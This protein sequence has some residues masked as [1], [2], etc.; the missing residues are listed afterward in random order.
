MK[1]IAA[2]VQ[3]TAQRTANIEAS[4]KGIAQRT[5]NI[6]ADAEKVVGT[7]EVIAAD[8]GKISGVADKL[9]GMIRPWACASTE[10]L[11][12]VH[13]PHNW[14]PKNYSINK[15]ELGSIW[16]PMQNELKEIVG[17]IKKHLGAIEK[18]LGAFKKHLKG[19]KMK[20]WVMGHASTL[21]RNDFNQRLSERRVQFVK[22]CLENEFKKIDFKPCAVGESGSAGNLRL[23][24]AWHRVVQVFIE[25]PP[26]WE[27]TD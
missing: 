6:E 15:C 23:P 3:G 25:K 13:F 22:S 16:V 12:A 18:H 27:C 7:A 2:G 26:Q 9:K 1:G 14:P 17:A 20:V 10:C 4:V 19:K 5:A 24:D 8:I 21:G 11:G